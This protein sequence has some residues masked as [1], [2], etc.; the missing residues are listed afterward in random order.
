MFARLFK[1]SDEYVDRDK[2]CSL[3]FRVLG[4]IDHFFKPRRHLTERM[5]RR[6]LLDVHQN[7]AG[8]LECLELWA[9][10]R[11]FFTLLQSRCHL[12]VEFIEFINTTD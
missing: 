3:I 8:L 2:L 10:S 7:L 5:R 4:T 9:V 6:I 1:D 11:N 12:L